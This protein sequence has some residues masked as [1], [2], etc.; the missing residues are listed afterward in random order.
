MIVAG[1]DFCG[2]MKKTTIKN[3]VPGSWVVL[4]RFL[5][6]NECV[7]RFEKRILRNIEARADSVDTV[8]DK[9]LVRIVG[10]GEI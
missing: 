10:T 9:D 7:D 5:L 2:E 8:E 1:C 6:C 4:R 3:P